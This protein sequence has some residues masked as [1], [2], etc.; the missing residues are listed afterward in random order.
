MNPV[1]RRETTVH[2]HQ[3]ICAGNCGLISRAG[4]V[5]FPT[6][7][8]SPAEERLKFRFAELPAALAVALFCHDF[9]VH[10]GRSARMELLARFRHDTGISR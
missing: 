9:D 10:R 1:Y 5:F 2:D 8:I 4:H 6:D 3:A 7:C